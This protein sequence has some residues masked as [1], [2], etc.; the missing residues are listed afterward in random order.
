MVTYL[1]FLWLNKGDWPT[2]SK[3]CN[4]ILSAIGD[5]SGGADVYDIRGFGEPATPDLDPYLLD[6]K[7]AFVCMCMR[8]RVRDCVRVCA[9]AHA[10]V[11][12]HVRVRVSVRVRVRVHV[13]AHVR[14]H[15]RVSGMCARA[16]LLMDGTL[17]FLASQLA[18]QVL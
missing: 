15:V 6:R 18:S 13:H 14:V 16:C 4:K 10:C 1:L 7:W 3:A 2:A 8:V 11:H 5:A 12:V 9:R 17:A